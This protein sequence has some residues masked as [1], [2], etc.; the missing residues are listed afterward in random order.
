[1]VAVLTVAGLTVSGSITPL[2]LLIL[3][4]ALSAGDAFKAPTWRALLPELVPK[5]DLPAA[6][7]TALNSTSPEPSGPAW[8]E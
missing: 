4:F 8:P 2:M 6:A 7:S 1:M 3:T 5:E